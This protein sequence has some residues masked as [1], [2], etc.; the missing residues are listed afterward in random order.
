[1]MESAT[2]GTRPSEADDLVS[3]R[4][5]AGNR[6]KHCVPAMSGLPPVAAP[7]I[8]YGSRPQIIA[9]TPHPI[10][11]EHAVRRWAGRCKSSAVDR[12]IFLS[13]H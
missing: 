6:F 12:W 8:G 1:V 13:N 5:N 7:C 4:V 9:A 10:E 3:T 2:V 11:V